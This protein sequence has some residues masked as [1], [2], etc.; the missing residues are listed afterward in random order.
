M[1]QTIGLSAA[2]QPGPS[3]VGAGLRKGA[4]RHGLDQEAPLPAQ[5]N[6]S[7]I[8]IVTTPFDTPLQAL[9]VILFNERPIPPLS[10]NRVHAR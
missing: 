4:G 7:L 3:I 9:Q 6:E 8:I 10:E 1:V 5:P 2:E